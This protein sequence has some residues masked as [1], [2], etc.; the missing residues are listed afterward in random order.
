MYSISFFTDSEAV[1]CFFAPKLFLTFHFLAVILPFQFVRFEAAYEE[2][3]FHCSSPCQE[4]SFLDGS[5]RPAA[6]SLDPLPA[7]HPGS[8][9]KDPLESPVFCISFG[10]VT[11]SLS[12]ISSKMAFRARSIF[13]SLAFCLKQNN[14]VSSFINVAAASKDGTATVIHIKIPTCTSFLATPVRHYSPEPGTSWFPLAASKGRPRLM[15]VMGFS[16]LRGSPG[17]VRSACSRSRGAVTGRKYH[18]RLFRL[19]RGGPPQAAFRSDRSLYAPSVFSVRQIAPG[20][21]Q[22]VMACPLCRFSL[23]RGTVNV[24]LLLDIQLSRSL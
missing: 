1:P 19:W 8:Y 7:S 24:P 14:Y 23:S 10:T 18:G 4:Y 13:S 5:Y 3:L 2:L 12:S 11:F 15:V 16:P 22:V 9:K 21:L 17:A 6:P 20:Y